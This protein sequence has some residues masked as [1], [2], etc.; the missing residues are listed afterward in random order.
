[1]LTN[2]YLSS[3]LVIN[4]LNYYMLFLKIKLCLVH[5]IKMPVVIADFEN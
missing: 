2:V 4:I 1:M 5:H 3:L